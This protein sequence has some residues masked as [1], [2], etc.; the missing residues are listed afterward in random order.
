M[1]HGLKWHPDYMS[2]EQHRWFESCPKATLFVIAH[3]LALA[4]DESQGFDRAFN[5]MREEWECLYG[6]GIVPQK[7]PRVKP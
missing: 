2:T 7:P 6:N 1:A 4:I 3:Y 5:R